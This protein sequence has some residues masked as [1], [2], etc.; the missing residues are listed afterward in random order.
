MNYDLHYQAS[1][2]TA[3][4]LPAGT[5]APEDTQLVGSF[6]YSPDD[7][8]PPLGP[9]TNHAIYHEVRELLYH[10]GVWDM[11]FVTILMPEVEPEEPEEP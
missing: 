1:S 3:T 8:T 6:V 2:K 4:V 10:I 7:A 11:G 9:D 5:T